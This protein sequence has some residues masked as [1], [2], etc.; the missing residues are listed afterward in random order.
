[1]TSTLSFLLEVAYAQI[2]AHVETEVL[3]HYRTYLTRSEELDDIA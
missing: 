2:S 1:M 3:R